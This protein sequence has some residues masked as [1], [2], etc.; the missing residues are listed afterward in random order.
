MSETG[1]VIFLH[2]GLVTLLLA[3]NFIL[4]A[5]HHGNIARVMVLA[6][7]AIGYNILLGYTGLLSLGHALFFAAGM[8]GMGLAIRH[9]GF[10][11]APALVMGIASG[12]ALSAAIGAFLIFADR[13]KDAAHRVANQP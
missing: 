6:S 1:K 8:Y 10:S 9:L 11:P 12:A 13:Y 3:L 4:P 2:A 5:Y 7:F